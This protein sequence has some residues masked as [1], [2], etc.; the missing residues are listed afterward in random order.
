ML[1]YKF[2]INFYYYAVSDVTCKCVYNKS[3]IR[4][5]VDISKSLHYMYFTNQQM[6][7]WQNCQATIFILTTIVRWKTSLLSEMDM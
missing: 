3:K 4:S 5:R 1:S 6:F 2:V 7:I